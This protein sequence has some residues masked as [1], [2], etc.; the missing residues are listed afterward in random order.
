VYFTAAC[1]K[2][3]LEVAVPGP[4]EV[5]DDPQRYW[6]F[7]TARADEDFESQYF[8]RKEAGRP[9]QS[10]AIKGSQLSGLADHIKQT[11]SAFANANKAGGLLVLGISKEGE[12][13]GINH[14]N[15]EQRTRIANLGEMLVNQS[16]RVSFVQCHDHV[17]QDDQIC[18]MYVPYS[19]R[20]ICE[21]PGKNPKSWNRQGPQNIPMT[22]Q[23]R[24]QMRRD[25]R[26]VDFEGTYCCP[27]DPSDVDGGVLREYRQA[28]LAEAAYEHSNEELLYQ[29]G[30]LSTAEGKQSFTNAGVL[31]FTSNPQRVL[32]SAYVRLLR[33]DCGVEEAHN[34]GLPTFDKKFTGP[35]TKQIRDLRTFL[36][37]TGFFKTY[38]R[39]KPE[40]GFAQEPEYPLIVVDEA[41]VNAVAHRDYA[42]GVPIVCE[43][44]YDAFVVRNPG[45][46]QQIDHDVPDR[47]SL[48]DTTLVSTP[49]NPAMVEWLR[50]IK[51][52][53][54]S[55]FV[56]ALSEGTKRMR[57]E[58]DR[59][60]LPAPVYEM[61]EAQTTVKL[62]N[63]AEEREAALRGESG[64]EPS[65]FAN[66]FPL[67]IS[68][69]GGRGLVAERLGRQ[70]REFTTSLG[71][72][73]MANGWYVDFSRFGRLKAHRR[74]SDIP[75]PT[76][77]ARLVRFYPAYTFQLRQYW[78]KNYLCVDYALEVKNVRNLRALLSE[79]D[80]G[81]LINRTAAV[82][83]EG[84][85]RGKIV[86]ADGEWALVHLFDLEREERVA[87]HNVIPNL[88]HA[89]IKASLNR[90]GVTFDFD[91]AIK[92]HGLSLEPGS[93]RTRAEKS[94]AVAE[95]LS[96]HVFPMLFDGGRL[97]LRARPAPLL[98]HGVAENAFRVDTLG[99]PSVEFGHRVELADI[100]DG[101]TRIGAYDDS[102]H[103]VEL[104][105]VCTDEMRNGMAALIERLKT[106]KYKYR[107]SERTF[108]TRF[109][110]ASIATVPSP[111][112]ALE[113]CRRL[114]REHRNWVGNQRVDRIFLVHTPEIGY[115]ADD[116]N[117]PYYRVKRFLLEYGVPCQMVDTSTLLNPDW[118]DLNLALN[119]AAKCNV[120][121]W[122]LPDAV[123]DADF[124]VGLSY[125]QSARRN[126]E[127]LMG[128]ANVFNEY[129]RWQF[130][131]GNTETFAYE[132]RED[133]FERLIKATMERL[134]LSETPNIYFHYSARF[135]R[136]DREAMLRAARSIR[137]QG[138]YCFV[139][140]NSHHNVRLYDNRV[141]TDGSL[142]RG[143]YVTA[144]PNQIYLSTTG[145]NPYRRAMGTPQMLEISAHVERPEGAPVSA[146]DLRSLAVQVLS[147]TKLNWA[148]TDSLCAEPITTKYA[149]D[150]AYL[151]AA[152]LRQDG[153]FNLHPVLEETPWFI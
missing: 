48:D 56:R 5:F 72:V 81:T 23:Q 57:D 145:Y 59:L 88:S 2:G 114:L 112:M 125:T 39:R 134:Q 63:N 135:S 126:H 50:T 41:I 121:P 123:P 122:V 139:W 6:G 144:A 62:Y 97:V 8:D 24:D 60:D 25:K 54:G 45:R 68:V 12:I 140:I 83:L 13:R 4:R 15:D 149:G 93:S 106:G 61:G 9:D 137:P 104:V 109:T 67:E 40:G 136:E 138:T 11:V 34:R 90:G 66:L 36:Q 132:D 53:D 133:N 26:I 70:R 95:E 150:I 91:R 75:L 98:R 18:L 82:R 99:E 110:Y 77:V 105:P 87:S 147:L 49:R 103:S 115:A 1:G 51:D 35:V 64:L 153:S 118:K 58:M 100:R 38:E 65:E 129:G 20:G 152:F 16:A 107:G 92:R 102:P 76:S 148:S 124:F 131:A 143:S 52:K 85:R 96:E 73:L 71:D 151:T 117:S 46:V 37:E 86:R 78:G 128:Y 89:E 142:S 22:Q 130:Y 80:V 27:F 127:R 29:V 21:T 101:I 94:Q 119:I 14:L 7:L 141:E 19:E 111:E 17:G 74:G 79:L 31:F 120:V 116:E 108:G 113:E 10:G 30:A 44:Y 42:M 69:N 43:S 47:F 84:W 55:A 28:I 146:P 32:P 33:F 3:S